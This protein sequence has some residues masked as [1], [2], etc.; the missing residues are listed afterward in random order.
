MSIIGKNVTNL[1]SEE[2]TLAEDFPK[3]KMTV[4]TKNSLKQ[5]EITFAKTYFNL[6]LTITWSTYLR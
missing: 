5:K 4:K 2:S 3:V 6:K 1:L